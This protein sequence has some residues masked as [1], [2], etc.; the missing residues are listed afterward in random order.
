[1]ETYNALPRALP[2]EA[3]MSAVRLERV[4]RA[5][6]Q[7]VDAGSLAHSSVLVSRCGLVVLED[8]HGC[9]DVE[10][11]IP[12]RADAI[13]RLMSMTKP[14]TACA[15]MICYEAGYFQLDDPLSDTLPEWAETKVF[16]GGNADEPQLADQERPITIR[17]LLTHTSG[18]NTIIG[19]SECSRMQARGMK[20]Y[21]RIDS[22]EAYSKAMASTPLAG[23]PGTR[24][25]Y[26]QG[27][28]ILGRAIEVWSGQTFDDFLQDHIFGPLGMVDTSFWCGS[29]KAERIPGAYAYGNEPGKLAQKGP[30]PPTGPPRTCDGSGGLMGTIADYFLFAQ[31]LCNKVRAE[32]ARP[33][34]LHGVELAVSASRCEI[35]YLTSVVLE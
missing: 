32:S 29:V 27:L 25:L 11:K 26:G 13:F 20:K 18:M 19:R 5:A 8:V 2:E 15:A 3:G 24:W 4:R 23:Q 12:L 22:L 1:M 31:M 28:S 35:I 17:H 9:S 21:G 6:R 30:P 34:T 7:H 33:L 10:S 14:I 16:I